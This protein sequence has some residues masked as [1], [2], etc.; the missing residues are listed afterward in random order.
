MT[1]KLA[2]VSFVLINNESTRKR[3]IERINSL[4]SLKMEQGS[5]EVELVSFVNR[6]DDYDL[7]EQ[8]RNSVSTKEI[9]PSLGR[10]E[11]I[12]FESLCIHNNGLIMIYSTDEHEPKADELLES[13]NYHKSK[14][15]KIDITCFT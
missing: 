14:L 1:Y 12:L 2:I 15:R 11:K 7:N 5:V 6:S 8:N 3:V 13:C 10:T 9:R 4:L